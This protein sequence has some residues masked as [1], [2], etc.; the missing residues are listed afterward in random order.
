[1]LDLA[2]LKIVKSLG[3]SWMAHEHCVK[4]V[5]ASYS[6]IVIALK[7]IYEQI[8]ECEALGIS[9]GVCKS[10]TVSAMYLHSYVVPQVAG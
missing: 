6:A 8:H 5:K 7:N 10:S 4:A 1:M 2:E 9:R 3:G